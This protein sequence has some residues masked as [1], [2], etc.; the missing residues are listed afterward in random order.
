MYSI[1]GDRVIRMM[2]ERKSQYMKDYR[3]KNSEKLR[4]Q[5]LAY[6][7]LHKEEAKITRKTYVSNN[8]EKIKTSRREYYLKHQEEACAYSK[9]YRIAHPEKVKTVLL[10]W[11]AQHAEEMRAYSARYRAEHLEILKEKD[12]HRPM[13]WQKRR[14]RKAKVVNDLT[15]RQWLF[16]KTI[17]R[18]RC[19]YCDKKIDR[20]TQDHITA[21]VHG[22]P[23][24]ASNIVPACRSCNAKKG[25]KGPPKP[26][27]PVL[28][29]GI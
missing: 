13:A 21:L 29:L 24:T 23:H 1:L 3:E 25:I 28:P 7:T 11:R 8:N 2:S 10:D 18:Q 14:A 6:K 19:A 26:I 20:L 17:F 12:R 16:I 9:D 15:E 5:N 27:Q 4:K 22:G